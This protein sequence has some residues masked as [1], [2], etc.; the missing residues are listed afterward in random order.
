[1]FKMLTWIFHYSSICRP[2]H[3]PRGGGSWLE[4]TKDYSKV[5][6]SLFFWNQMPEPNLFGSGYATHCDVVFSIYIFL[7]TVW[8]STM[9]VFFPLFFIFLTCLVFFSWI[10]QRKK[11]NEVIKIIG[12]KMKVNKKWCMDSRRHQITKHKWQ[13]WIFAL[14]ATWCFTRFN[15]PHTRRCTTVKITKYRLDFIKLV[16][17]I[18]I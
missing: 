15:A 13:K 8:Y 18:I 11:V 7:T 3:I 6:N 14:Q 17:N 4:I 16:L 1:M 5:G 10:A 2:L 9:E 12:K